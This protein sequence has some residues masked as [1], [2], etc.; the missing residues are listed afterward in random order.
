MSSRS[1]L[2]AEYARRS[3]DA[4]RIAGDW[5]AADEYVRCIRESYDAAFYAAG[6]V[7][8]SRGMKAGTHER[9]R[10]G[11][12]DLAAAGVVPAEMSFRLSD[13]FD[14]RNEA[15]YR[16]ARTWSREETARVL[17]AAEGLASDLLAAVE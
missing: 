7:L 12:V 13:L 9:L 6:A 1:R 2:S 4:L 14:T 16:V 8:V 11:L 17:A 3:A 5:L 10:A 15:A